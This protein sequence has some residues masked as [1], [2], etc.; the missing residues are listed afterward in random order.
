MTEEH[1]FIHKSGENRTFLQVLP[2]TD[3]KFLPGPK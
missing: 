2:V 1:T 3:R